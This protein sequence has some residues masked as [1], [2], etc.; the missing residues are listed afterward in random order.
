MTVPEVRIGAHA[1]VP[2]STQRTKLAGG[3][4]HLTR[5]HKLLHPICAIDAEGNAA[6]DGRPRRHVEEVDWFTDTTLGQ[7]CR[8]CRPLMGE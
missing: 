8:L 5:E 3:G 7:K 2:S 4:E 6:C 1:L